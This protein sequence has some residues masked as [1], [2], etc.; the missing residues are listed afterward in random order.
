MEADE[1]GTEVPSW[2]V[3]EVVV[4]CKNCKWCLSESRYLFWCTHH[5]CFTDVFDVYEGIYKKKRR[6]N[7]IIGLLYVDCGTKNKTGNCP[8][9]EAISLSKKKRRRTND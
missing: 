5:S 3:G 9:F 4:A 2:E 1:V 8:D 7:G 6:L